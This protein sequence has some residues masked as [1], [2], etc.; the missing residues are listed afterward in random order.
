MICRGET[1]VMK[2]TLDKILKYNYH[3]KNK[4]AKK[5]EKN[6]N[7]NPS[8]IVEIKLITLNT[9]LYFYLM[10]LWSIGTKMNNKLDA[11]IIKK[12]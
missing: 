9:E 2:N 10:L 5:Y 3:P 12:T 1:K 11:N 7:D 4:R 8:P 6:S